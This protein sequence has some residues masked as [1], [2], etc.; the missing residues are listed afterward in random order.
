MR[1]IYTRA[2]LLAVALALVAA[3]LGTDETVIWG[4]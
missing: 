2:V 1:F 4:S 3:F